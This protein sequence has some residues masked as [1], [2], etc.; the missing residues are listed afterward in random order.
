MPRDARKIASSLTKKGFR[1][2]EDRDAYF[3][4][5]V[6]ERKTPIF[7]KMSQGETEIHDGLLGAMARQL[8][9]SKRD[10]LRLVDCPLTHGQYVQ[11]LR[12]DG[13]IA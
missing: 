7:T 1:R 12:R 4:L 8:Q 5:Y 3:H 6:N 13:R 11:S 10:F 9:L 2:R